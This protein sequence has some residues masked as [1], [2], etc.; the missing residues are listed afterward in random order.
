MINQI[1]YI[2]CA[3]FGITYFCLVFI[4]G[5]KFAPKDFRCS[6]ILDVPRQRLIQVSYSLI[7]KAFFVFVYLSLETLH[8]IY[9]DSTPI[10]HNLS[11]GPFVESWANL[12]K[13]E[14]NWKVGQPSSLT[15]RPAF[16]ATVFLTIGYF[17]RGMGLYLLRLDKCSTFH[18]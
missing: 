12:Y 17:P 18:P 5:C 14:N 10:W 6:D 9:P 15:Y 1:K 4:Q 2:K 8:W 11:S 3:T 16:A 7:C 13:D